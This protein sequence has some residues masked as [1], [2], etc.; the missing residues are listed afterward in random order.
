MALEGGG[1][2]HLPA[3]TH[4]DIRPNLGASH[5]ATGEGSAQLGHH[6]LAEGF[7][8]TV[9]SYGSKPTG[10]TNAGTMSLASGDQILR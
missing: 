7:S 5:T 10:T 8:D 2:V 1:P 6:P 9:G 4:A 3:E